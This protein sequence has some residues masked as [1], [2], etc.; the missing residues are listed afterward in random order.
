MG[1]RQREGQ[2]QITPT[3]LS[4]NTGQQWPRIFSSGHRAGGGRAGGGKP[5]L[6]AWRGGSSPALGEFG[7]LQRIAAPLALR[8]V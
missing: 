3:L 1:S 5:P 2:M 4:Q 8:Q 7:R 6:L